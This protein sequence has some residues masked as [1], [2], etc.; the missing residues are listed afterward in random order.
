MK[1]RK[2]SGI[3]FVRKG[4]LGESIC[5][6]SGEFAVGVIVEHL[7]EVCAS[8]RSATEVAIAFT[9][10]EVSVRPAAAPGRIIE[11]FVILRG[12]QSG[13]ANRTNLRTWFRN[14]T[15]V[16]GEVPPVVLPTPRV[17][18]TSTPQVQPVAVQEPS[19][20]SLS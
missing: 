18:P 11:I 8:A 5:C 1:Q 17:E 6:R 20:P 14:R 4:H 13:I 12:R 3:I 2:R 19:V 15:G 10:R 16:T 7:L 9:Q